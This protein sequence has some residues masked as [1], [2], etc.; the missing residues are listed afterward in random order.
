MGYIISF[1]VILCFCQVHASLDCSSY[2]NDS[3]VLQALPF[4]VPINPADR[5]IHRTYAIAYD[6]GTVFYVGIASQQLI[7]STIFCLQAVRELSV[8]DSSFCDNESAVCQLSSEIDRWSSSF[9]TLS[10]FSTRI[11]HLP[12]SI[13]KL[14]QLKILELWNTGL[15]TLPNS[16]SSLTSLF[17]LTITF[18]QLKVLPKGIGML[19]S[20]VNIYLD[21]NNDLR[22]VQSLNGLPNLYRL[23]TINCSITS[24]PMNLPKIFYLVMTNNKLTNLNGIR[25]LGSQMDDTKIF[26]FDINQ[27]RAVPSEINQVYKMVTLNLAK[28]QL[29]NLPSTIFG[30]EPLGYL[31]IQHNSFSST[32]LKNIVD[33][34]KITNPRMALLY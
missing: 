12:A 23:S 34:F 9:D 4:H 15:V 19:S 21:N 18:S 33:K 13:G 2:A 8:R 16:F 32:I 7:P 24:I 25:T 5:D 20:L 1:L 27:I 26:F 30:Y 28:N 31:N 29:T 11:T 17:S 22:S 10:I 3:E 14:H 6:N